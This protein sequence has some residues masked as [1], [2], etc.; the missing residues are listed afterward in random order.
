M[1]TE[2]L[3]NFA[4]VIE[5]KSINAAAS[6]LR[7]SQSTLTRRIQSLESEIGFSLLERTTSGITLT[8]AGQ[9]FH[10]QVVKVLPALS[11]A[12][13][14]AQNIASGKQ[15]SIRI[16]YL[17]STTQDF[18]N[19]ALRKFKKKFPNLIVE[20]FDL[21]PGEQI[22]ALRNKEIDL[23][24]IGQSG[25]TIAKEFTIQKIA[26]IPPIV[27]MSEENPYSQFESCRLEDLKTQRFIIPPEKDVPGYDAWIKKL[28]IKAN[29]KPVFG[30]KPESLAQAMS[31]IITN[32]KLVYILPNY[33][34]NIPSPGIKFLHIDNA[35][36]DW[37]FYIAHPKENT[38]QILTS[39]INCFH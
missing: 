13:Q 25:E 36:I 2:W 10:S 21:S 11:S 1:N 26:S 28:C 38:P 9:H 24:I 16:G 34:K 15:S 18:L 6:K 3:E 8:P 33:I 30:P 17:M 39:F 37:P 23:A 27:A 7:L 29:F 5:E 22:E 4:T 31:F 32:E 20:L 12:I 19:P 35:S 14:E